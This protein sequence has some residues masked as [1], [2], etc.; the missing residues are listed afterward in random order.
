MFVCTCSLCS[1]V[2]TPQTSTQYFNSSHI[3]CNF[4][5]STL[6]MTWE[7]RYRKSQRDCAIR[8]LYTSPFIYSRR[9]KSYGINTGD[10]GGK[11]MGR[12]VLS[13]RFEIETPFFFHMD[14][15][16]VRGWYTYVMIVVANKNFMTF[17]PVLKLFLVCIYNRFENTLIFSPE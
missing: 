15:S 17:L 1:P 10:L 14:R 12:L 4:D 7:T 3:N 2:V 8:G 6:A 5:S 11:G 9:Y 16:A 13:K